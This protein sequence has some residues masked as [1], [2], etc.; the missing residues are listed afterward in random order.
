L[1][2]VAGMVR[3]SGPGSCLDCPAGRYSNAPRSRCISC[4]AGQYSI[5]KSGQC[6]VCSPGTYSTDGSSNC[7]ECPSGYYS[8][9]PAPRCDLCSTGQ[10]SNKKS[11]QSYCTP[12]R[13]RYLLHHVKG[14]TTK[15]ELPCPVGDPTITCV[16]DQKF[17]PGRIWHRPRNCS[18]K[19]TTEEC[20][21]STEI[22]PIN[23]TTKIYICPTKGCPEKGNSTMLC[24]GGYS[25]W[26]R[27]PLCAVCEEGFFMRLGE[28]MACD[29]P[30]IIAAVCVAAALLST[31]A[32][33]GRYFFKHQRYI[34]RLGFYG[35]LKIFASFFTILGTVDTQFGVT[36]PANLASVLDWIGA[37]GFNFNVF[38]SYFCLVDL[39]LYE[40]V[41]STTLTI[42]AACMILLILWKIANDATYLAA[43]IYLNIFVYPT[44]ST[45]IAEGLSC[46][47]VEGTLYHAQDYSLECSGSRFEVY[48]G[49]MISLIVL[50]VVGFPLVVL[51][52][53]ALYRNVLIQKGDFDS[54]DYNLGFLVDDF[55]K[56]RVSMMWEFVEIIRKLSLSLVGVCF[57][58]K[59]PISIAC[60]LLLSVTFWLLHEH[61]QPFCLYSCNIS[62]SVCMAVLSALYFCGLLIRINTLNEAQEN[63]I[64]NLLIAILALAG[65]LVLALMIYQGRIFLKNVKM[66]FHSFGILFEGRILDKHGP[67]DVVASFP[68]KY[69]NGWNAVVSTGKMDEIS[70]ACVYLPQGTPRFGDHAIDPDTG[71]CYCHA[72]YGKTEFWGC[73]WFKIWADLIEKAVKR[74]QQ[75]KVYYFPDEVG[76][77]EVT[78]DELVDHSLLRTEVMKDVPKK[79]DGWPK[80]LSAKENEAYLATLT[81]DQRHTMVGLG[82]SQK[83][84]LAYLKKRRQE[85]GNPGYDVERIDVRVML[86]DRGVKAMLDKERLLDK[87][88]LEWQEVRPRLLK[89]EADELEAAMTAASKKKN[90]SRMRA[91]L[92]HSRDDTQPPVSL[93]NISEVLVSSCSFNSETSVPRNTLRN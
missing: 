88:G 65:G 47:S 71:R 12:V 39:D 18:H 90:H 20:A 64:G 17:Y 4:V 86:V 57:P 45:S 56:N 43:A 19:D 46:H 54:R 72:L 34:K 31:L 40:S 91:L 70:V 9:K 82:G 36:W 25:Q 44:L 3:Q 52:Q 50:W 16:Q 67:V 30:N 29:E 42:L 58:D 38:T 24:K 49:Y 13:D 76:K 32:V 35:H 75:L 7:L 81:P 23:A 21:N 11:G 87:L 33:C 77:G 83:G 66:V 73:M 14:S 69:E 51:R 6:T 68:G 55:K 27:A 74:G 85:T 79:E 22:L 8:E 26:P 48:R 53:L 92:E 60:A 61:N 59:G 89:T 93:S 37:A 2:C 62:Q 28:C 1:E 84:E 41:L 78:W 63:Q 5:K 15:V 10:Y 80:K